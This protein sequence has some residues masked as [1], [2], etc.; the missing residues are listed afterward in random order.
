M[1]NG[2]GIALGGGNIF[3]RESGAVRHIVLRR[4]QCQEH[5]GYWEENINIM[6]GNEK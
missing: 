2:G 3:G 1:E 6:G 5:T 4:K